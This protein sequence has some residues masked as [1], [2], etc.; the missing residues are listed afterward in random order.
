V[1]DS[2]TVKSQSATFDA[3]ANQD[4][5]KGTPTLYVGKSGGKST[6]VAL[7]SATDGGPVVQAIEHALAA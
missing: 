3:Q 5:V 7:R 1:R 2:S 6:Q 4:G